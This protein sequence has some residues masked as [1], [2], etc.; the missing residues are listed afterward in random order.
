MFSRFY[1][2]RYGY[3]RWD[4]TQRIEGLDADDIL[5]ALSDDYMEN[6][7]LQQA[8]KRLMQEGIRGED[9]RRAMGLRE[10]MERLRNQRNEQLNRYNMASG[11]M[12][13]LRQ[14]LEEIKQL[15]RQGI[16]R[17]LDNQLG[18]PGEQGQQGQQGQQSPSGSQQSGQQGQ[19]S[20]SG[21][22]QSGQQGQQGQRGQQM[23]SGQQGQ[24]GEQGQSGQAGQSGQGQGNDDLTP[25]QMRKMLEM[26]AKRKREYLDS[27]PQDVPGQIK[28]LSEY[29]FMDD[30]A[31]EKFQELMQSLQQQMMQQF[32]QGMQQSLQNMTPED[33]ARLR[34]MIRELNQM[35]RERQEGREPDFDSFMQKYGD[36]FPGVNSLDDLIEQ[37]QMQMA[38]MQGI[39]D[40]LSPEQRQELQDLMDQ[41]IGDDRIRVDMMELAQNLEALAPM[42]QIRTRFP[43]RGSE[44]LPL[45]EAMRMMSRL[46]QMEGLEDQFHEARRLDDIE[47]IDSEKVKELLGDEEYQSI[48]QLKELMKMLEEAGYIQKKG[49]R[50]ELTARGIRKIGQKALQD[51][52]NK[53][54]RDGFGRHVSPFRGVGGERT[55]ESKAYQFGDPFLLD[56]EK[57]LMNAIHRRGVGTP[58]TLQKDDFEVYRTEFTT[59]S[60]TVLMI[61]MS[62]SMIYNGC[63]PAAKK[64]AVALESLIRSQFPRDNLY[65]VGFSF[66]AREYKP[67][68]LI[69]MSR[70]DNDRGTNMA[71]GLML[72]RQ[73]LSRHRGVN[74]QIIMITDGGPTVWYE[75]KY[76]GWQ[77]AYPS[78]YA[79]QQT[80]LEVQR[81]TREG[82]TINTFML[83]D[84][85]WMV[86]FV[87]QMAE[88][89]HGR[90]FYT[91]KDNLGEYLLVDYL[92]SKRKFVS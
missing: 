56:L 36:Y 14:K 75:E 43:F 42:E 63:Q 69:E 59:Q 85:A 87:N 79:E 6:G 61:D 38:A 21:S 53:L 39:L 20:P 41:L 65:I 49:N 62:L 54:K 34:E 35:L 26:I 23:Q 46:Q 70:Y 18:Q 51:I 66:I 12:D 30:E 2:N 80:L 57:T 88:I 68:E 5:K 8:L 29:D 78:P 17:R 72:A 11:V 7:N 1:R 16:Q 27:L 91:D 4:G 67:N 44:T 33:I 13:D 84:D 50:W 92:N 74:K 52:F 58:V 81:C 90:T 60:S 28:K 47:S 64:V 76:G 40:N 83:Y 15:E 71:H 86:A 48:E 37:M 19:Q 45:N 24:Q 22:Q 31:R 77:F 10:M 9:G 3:S 55:D 82:I 25:E 73:L 32:F 89:N